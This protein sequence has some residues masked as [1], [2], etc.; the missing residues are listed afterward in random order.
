MKRFVVLALIVVLL[1]GCQKKNTVEYDQPTGQLSDMSGYGIE[2][3]NFYD[4]TVLELLE[5][6]NNNKT[7]IVY[8]GRTNCEWCQA[9]MPYLNEISTENELK[10]YYLDILAQDDDNMAHIDE[11]AEKCREFVEIDSEG[12]PI[13]RVPSVLYIQEGKVVNFHEGTVNTHDATA[14]EMTEKEVERLKYNLRKEF[15]S[16]LVKQ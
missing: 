3:G 14:R 7:V 10:L 8:M 15:D 5:I 6:F 16:V 11:V 4:I 2:D 9:L 1:T 12:A 13:L